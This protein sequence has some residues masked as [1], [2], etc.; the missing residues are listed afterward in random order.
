MSSRYLNKIAKELDRSGRFFEFVENSII[1]PL[2]N[3]FGV[4]RIR[5]YEE[6]KDIIELSDSIWATHGYMEAQEYN[7]STTEEAIG[8][9]IECIFSG[10]LKM[11]FAQDEFGGPYKAIWSLAEIRQADKE[12][13]TYE[14]Q[15]EI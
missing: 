9:F 15:S 2:P 7:L 8:Y 3:D 11:V 6:G 10:K 5:E 13:Y 14:V 12:N 1:I 4:L